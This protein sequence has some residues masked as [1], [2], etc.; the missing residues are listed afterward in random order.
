MSIYV[1]CRGVARGAGRQ[2]PPPLEV[3]F[4]HILWT[5]WEFYCFAAPLQNYLAPDCP[6]PGKTLATP[7]VWCLCSAVSTLK[8]RKFSLTHIFL[9]DRLSLA[10]MKNKLVMCNTS[11]HVNAKTQEK[12]RIR[13]DA[14]K[15][16]FILV[17]CMKPRQ[18]ARL[19]GISSA[20][21]Y[22]TFIYQPQI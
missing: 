3:G 9:P 22:F 21:F 18:M 5:C 1:W 4:L 14:R 13:T 8:R 12:K 15:L 20:Y 16:E 19:H 17:S 2:L 11:G 6:P 7:L 10:T